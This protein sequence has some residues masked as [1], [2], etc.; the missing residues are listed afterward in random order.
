MVERKLED[1]SF[2]NRK[3]EKFCLVNNIKCYKN[4]NCTLIS[5]S[6]PNCLDQIL[7]SIFTHFVLEVLF[8]RPIKP[9]QST[10]YHFIKPVQRA[11]QSNYIDRRNNP[12]YTNFHTSI[13]EYSILDCSN[14]LSTQSSRCC[15]VQSS[16]KVGE[17]W[18]GRDVSASWIAVSRDLKPSAGLSAS[19]PQIEHLFA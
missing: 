7:I 15:C 16:N 9:H 12:T 8:I 10:L 6:S 2:R 4:S 18:R 1:F 3:Q 5:F 11:L 14:T 17:G 13:L 19:S